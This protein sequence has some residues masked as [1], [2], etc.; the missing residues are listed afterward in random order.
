ML[1]EVIIPS[2]FPFM[3]ISSFCLKSDSFSPFKRLSKKLLNK[4][5][6]LPEEAFYAVFFGLLSG[7]PVGMRITAQLYEENIISHTQAKRLCALCVNGGPAFII[8]AVGSMT[9]RSTKAGVI[10]LISCVLSSFISAIVLKYLMPD[11]EDCHGAFK[12]KR[13]DMA[14]VDAVRDSSEGIINISAWIILFSS[15]LAVLRGYFG[16]ELFNIVSVVAE[17]TVGVKSAAKIGGLPLACAAL[18]F[19]GLCVFLQNLPA[20]KKCEIKAGYYLFIRIINSILSFFICR[21][22]LIFS[23]VY[24][25]VSN[26]VLKTNFAPAVFALMLMCAALLERLY[27]KVNQDDCISHLKEAYF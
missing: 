21:V 19:G 12:R 11:L 8:T 13:R 14:L 16:E 9:F 25:S 4:L 23:P 15:L 7:Y 10:L 18:S 6:G 26:F 22:I 20:I 3:V 5:F 2:L 24:V 1:G 17:V 27:D